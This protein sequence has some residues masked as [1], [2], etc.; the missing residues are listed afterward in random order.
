M[1]LETKTVD[2]ISIL[3]LEGMVKGGADSDAL[4]ETVDS[5]L[6]KDQKKIILDL[7]QV[8]F[9]N[10]SGIGAFIRCYTTVK[11]SGGVFMIANISEKIES[12]LYITKLHRVIG[13]HKT[14]D[15]AIN[16]INGE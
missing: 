16:A 12:V 1:K 3:E 13:L 2:G 5:L 4:Y 9:V 11:D 14:L 7:H 8:T 15:D 6:E 10:S